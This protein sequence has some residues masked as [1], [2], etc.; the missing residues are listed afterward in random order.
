MGK[1]HPA[2]KEW[3]KWKETIEGMKCLKD[4]AEGRFLENRLFW[5]F[6]AGWRAAVRIIKIALK[7]K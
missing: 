4:E 5:A 2:N 1:K 7:D 6:M 3:K